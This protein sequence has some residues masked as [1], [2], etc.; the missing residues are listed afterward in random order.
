MERKP[1]PK[2]CKVCPEKFTP[3]VST[4]KVCSPKCGIQYTREQEAKKQRKDLKDRKQKLM[5]KSDW[6]KLAQAEFN[7]FIRLRDKDEPCISCGRYHTGQYHAGHYRTVGANP[8]LRFEELN[9]HKQCSACNNHKS[10]N[11]VEYRIN[12]VRKIGQEAIDWLEGPHDPLK[13]TVEQIQKIRKKYRDKCK[14]LENK[15]K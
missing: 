15:H 4:Q 1:K 8:E 5:T 6:M 9:C 7:K 13:L 10:G 3:W 2:K 14:E 11:I 12:L